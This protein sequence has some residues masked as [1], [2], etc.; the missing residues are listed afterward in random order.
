[1][2]ISMALRLQR[3]CALGAMLLT[4]C[5]Q[6]TPPATAQFAV[7]RI[8]P[9]LRDGASPLL[10]NDAITVYFSAAVDPMSVTRDSFAVLN[11]EGH[12][13]RGRLRV[14]G[15]WI[16]FEPE[17]PLSADLQ[18]G[19]FQPGQDYRLV[20]T[21]YPRADGVRAQRGQL[22]REGVQHSFH[23][24]SF[25]GTGGVAPLRPLNAET[26]PFLLRPSDV[27]SAPLPVD[28]ARLQLHFTLPLLPPS[29][30]AAAFEMRL[31]RSLPA[32]EFE[33]IEP[34]AVRLLPQQPVDDCPGSTVEIEFGAQVRVR[35]TDQLVALQPDD[36]VVVRLVSGEKALR[37]YAG[38]QPPPQVQW[39]N[40]VPGV[41]V[42][43]AE[44]PLP[45]Q[46]PS[47]YL[48]A[49]L[50]VPGFEV[51]DRQAIQ[52]LV[53]VEAGDGSLGVLRPLRDTQIGGDPFDRGDGVRV[54]SADGV[55]AFQAIDIPAG[56]TVRIDAGPRPVH[57]L[58]L[59]RI[60]IAGRL[61]VFGDSGPMPLHPGQLVDVSTLCSGAVVSVLAG[62]GIEVS[63]SIDGHAPNG[64][65]PVALITSGALIVTGSIP[66]D[67]VLA[68]ERGG[69]VAPRAA[70]RCLAVRV[71]LTA[72]L[73]P[74]AEVL[75]SGY[76]PFLQV[77]VDRTAGTIR[78]SPADT[79]V[80]VAWQLL[81]PDSL[82]RT[83]P[84]L[85]PARAGAP[86][87]IVDGQRVGAG[88]GSFLRLRLQARV[89][90]GAPLPHLHGI[91]VLDR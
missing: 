20:V 48:D 88:P 53:R 87:E 34:R 9:D 26:R 86:R 18:D 6:R 45:Q 38:R 30:T 64:G 50:A 65:A 17:P 83:R 24:A 1:M 91:D 80:R 78:L 72:G 35:D 22:L 16:T 81:P 47:R 42:R 60:R 68:T 36:L 70:D 41:A 67:S 82:Q 46:G 14:D 3:W 31:L 71:Q 28:D 51:T 85:D 44:W 11:G 4:A 54:A 76:T 5:W 77:P 32:R 79:P 19:S 56:V 43:V 29:V 15:A 61:E 90:A 66:P 89:A 40:V 12:A 27:G 84:D 63:G 21:G 33:F 73:P 23:I 75:A 62:S 37:D 59:G 49:D 69:L 39:C 57:L 58:A 55:F 10:L 74:G 52:P 8:S 25:D 7:A 13:V 2:R